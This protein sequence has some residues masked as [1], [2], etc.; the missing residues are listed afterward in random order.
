MGRFLLDSDYP[1]II[2]TSDLDQITEG[3]QQN[4]LDAETRAISRMRSKLVQRYVVD[5][6]L[7]GNDDYDAAKHYRSGERVLDTTIYHV[8]SFSVYAKTTAYIAGNIVTDEYYYVYTCI[9]ANTGKELTDTAY[10]EPMI[11]IDTTDADYWENV[12][13]RYPLFVELALDMTL[14]NLHARLNPRNIP[15]I[16]VERN[17]EALDQLDAWASGDDTAEVLNIIQPEGQGV[18]I[19]YGASSEKQTNNF[20]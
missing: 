5:I 4:L 14:Y 20:M 7:G 12:D 18:S 1:S 16:R 8:L 19:T 9:Q 6:E 17:R 3:V 2:Q 13:N 15:T 11:N 10:W